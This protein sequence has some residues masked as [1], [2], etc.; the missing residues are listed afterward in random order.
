MRKSITILCL[1]LSFTYVTIGQQPSPG[2]QDTVHWIKLGEATVE[3]QNLNDEI[4]VSN[5]DKFDSVKFSVTQS[6]LNLI[7]LE[8]YYE[9]GEKQAV[10][11]DL[12]VNTNERSRAIELHG[13]ERKLA[14]IAFIY[15]ALPGETEKKTVL[16]I[17]GVKKHQ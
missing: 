5:S 17:W 6:P 7:N 16:Q 13:G 8:F 15:S 4:K 11:T 1:A 12:T 9:T 14:K 3:F 2:S 10:K